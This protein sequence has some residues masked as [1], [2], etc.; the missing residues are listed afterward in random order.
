MSGVIKEDPELIGKLI[1]DFLISGIKSGAITFKPSLDIPQIEKCLVELHRFY[2]PPLSRQRRMYRFFFN[3]THIRD[4]CD[5]LTL[6]EFQWLLHGFDASK[7]GVADDFEFG[8]P[9]DST[10]LEG[11]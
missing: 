2:S 4:F 6:L 5:I 1:N 3:E 8:L 10:N 11:A 9:F 7:H